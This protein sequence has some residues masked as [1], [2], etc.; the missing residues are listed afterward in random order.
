[1]LMMIVSGCSEGGFKESRTFWLPWFDGSQYSWNSVPIRTLTSYSPMKGG[2]AALVIQPR[3]RDNQLFGQPPRIHWFFDLTTQQGVA[4]DVASLQAL[5]VYAHMERLMEMDLE[6]GGYGYLNW[7]RKVAL[8]ARVV[9][10]NGDQLA[11]NALYM[12]RFD[13]IIVV[14]YERFDLPISMNGGVIAHEHFHALFQNIVLKRLPSDFLQEKPLL[15]MFCHS[16]KHLFQQFGFLPEETI[17]SLLASEEPDSRDW[18]S[19]QPE[20][21]AHRDQ[22]NQMILRAWNEG[23]ADFWGWLYLD[24]SDF[25]FRSRRE[26]GNVRE[27]NDEINP[28]PEQTY[29]KLLV[30]NSRSTVLQRQAYRMGTSLA[31]FLKVILVSESKGKSL[32]ETLNSERIAAARNFMKALELLSQEL[33]Q[34]P[35]G[36]YL[37][38]LRLAEVVIQSLGNEPTSHQC[39]AFR[40]LVGGSS[41][42]DKMILRWC[43]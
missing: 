32:Q 10:G 9:E 31:R 17:G 14:N 16:K 42:G 34:V 21:P 29:L 23:S 11:S 19:R 5:V 2:A 6:A 18:E 15:P 4:R 27:L 39:E 20:S 36:S 28:L 22:Y 37:S 26:E 7:P 24:D 8:Q 12:P 43:P 41:E 40:S 1:M 3:Y 33:S 38:P 25:V 13:A 35:S 30:S